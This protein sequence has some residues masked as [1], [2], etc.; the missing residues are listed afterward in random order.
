MS[1]STKVF[2]QD[3]S[4]VLG[5]RQLYFCSLRVS[6]G[7]YPSLGKNESEIREFQMGWMDPLESIGSFKSLLHFSDCI[8]NTLCRRHMAY[9]IRAMHS[10]WK[11]KT[12]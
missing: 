12:T 11:M 6:A 10:M 9:H 3:S 1:I 8:L 2:L 5:R 4:L 7:S